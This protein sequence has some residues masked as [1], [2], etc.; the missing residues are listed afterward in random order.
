MTRFKLIACFN[1]K[2]VLGKD[3]HLIWRIGNDMANFKRQ[4]LGNVVIM[5]RKTFESLPNGEPLKNR[6]NVII[7]SNKEFSV[8]K[9]YDNVYIVNSIE[10]AIELCEAF[11][12][13]KEVFVIGGESIYREFM[14]RGLVDEMRLTIV[15]DEAD[16]DVFF[17]EYDEN[18]WYVYYKSMAQVS[19]WEGVDK[20]F[21]YEIL[22][23]KND[24]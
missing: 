9:D 1:K 15:N 22:S 16:G 10:D 8:N 24:E 19:S 6:I 13:G 11:F 12:D 20:S 5:G 17:P 14:E 2:R 23:K 21:Y 18:E 3:G 7:T 4:T